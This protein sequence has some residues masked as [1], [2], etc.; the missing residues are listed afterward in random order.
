MRFAEHRQNRIYEFVRITERTRQTS[1]RG[2]K[3]QLGR[4]EFPHEEKLMFTVAGEQSPCCTR[5]VY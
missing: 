3:K 4:F 5:G 2:R 1:G